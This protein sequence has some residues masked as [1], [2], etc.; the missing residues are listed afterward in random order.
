MMILVRRTS[1]RG[2][3]LALE[4]SASPGSTLGAVAIGN[5]RTFPAGSCRSPHEMTASVTL[6][7][8]RSA[9]PAEY[10]KAQERDLACGPHH[11]V[12]AVE[13][14]IRTRS[15][16]RADNPAQG[17]LGT[18]HTLLYPT[19][20]SRLSCSVGLRGSVVTSCLTNK[21]TNETLDRDHHLRIDQS[22]GMH[23]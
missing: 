17:T 4:P 10:T 21:E 15:P 13:L 3:Q 12:C 14:R 8:S 16:S 7:R 22:P 1:S 19:D 9:Q 20:P 6:N 2:E 18:Y 5:P 23:R 11:R